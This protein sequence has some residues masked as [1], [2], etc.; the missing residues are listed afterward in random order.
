MTNGLRL[1]AKQALHKSIE[2]RKEAQF[3]LRSPISVFDLCEKKGIEIE[4][5][6]VSM[7][8]MYIKDDIPSIILST[9]RPL[10]RQHFTC[11]HELG[12]HVFGHGTSFDE[13]V[14]NSKEKRFDPKEF[15][16]NSFAGFLLMP[17]IGVRKAFASRGW[18]PAS[19]TPLQMF[20]VACSFSVG[21]TTL[22]NHMA[23]GLEIIDR[24]K[25]QLLTKTRLKT[26]RQEAL[27]GYY[28]DPLIIAD[29]NWSL[30]TLD[31]EVGSLLLLP[32]T[33]EATKDTITLL[34]ENPLGRL[35]RANNPGIV[36]VYCPN[37]EWAVSVRISRKEFVG[38]NSY[39]HKEE[40]NFE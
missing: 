21:F 35:F 7:E 18:S 29:T 2:V 32:K 33:A 39:R 16:V 1:L 36:D 14:E 17:I 38:L 40:I 5:V 9:L 26:I 30:P 22:I 12:H 24:A 19:A 27:G 15:M 31:G 20:I 25:A 8:G 23:Y 4:F 11:A 6:D 28:D 37:S 34:S 10:V 13:L 3:D